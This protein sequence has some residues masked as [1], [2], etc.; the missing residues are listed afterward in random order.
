VM[1]TT[2]SQSATVAETKSTSTMTIENASTSLTEE[3]SST[4]T[5]VMTTT[6]NL[7]ASLADTKLTSTMTTEMVPSSLRISSSVTTLSSSSTE[8]RLETGISAINT[9][10]STSTEY[11][12]SNQQ[13]TSVIYSTKTRAVPASS[14]QPNPDEKEDT[15]SSRPTEMPAATIDTTATPDTSKGT[16]GNGIPTQLIVAGA[17]GGL[18]RLFRLDSSG[19]NK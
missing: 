5:S 15:V 12:S 3:L 6:S 4:T 7:S 1:T 10:D 9:I 11:K 19:F 14:S 13:T 18:G 16:I 8:G 17:I 2:S